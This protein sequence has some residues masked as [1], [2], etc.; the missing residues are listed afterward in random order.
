MTEQKAK[1]KARISKQLPQ[2]TRL[3]KQDLVNDVGPRSILCITFS[4]N[5]RQAWSPSC[6]RQ[7]ST[8]LLVLLVLLLLAR[9]VI[10]EEEPK[11][12][13]R[14]DLD[15]AKDICLQP[16]HDNHRDVLTR[17]IYH[18]ATFFELPQ[19]I[20]VSAWTVP[21][22]PSSSR[23]RFV[24]V[25]SQESWRDYV[26]IE[27]WTFFRVLRHTY[28]WEVVDGASWFE[29]AEELLRDGRRAPAVLLFMEHWGL[30]S[31]GPID[32]RLNG[33]S[34]WLFSDDLNWFGGPPA[35]AQKASAFAVADVLA[36]A[37]MPSLPAIFPE[38]AHKPRVH[39]P[40]AVSPMFELPM[41]T[42]PVPR[43]LLSGQTNALYPYRV[44]A[45]RRALAGDA[46]FKLLRHPGYWKNASAASLR[47]NSSGGSGVVG[48]AYAAALH[49]HLAA[50]TDGTVFNRSVAKVFEIPATGALLL[51]NAELVPVLADVGMRPGAH[52]VAY[53]AA[54][55][56]AVVDWVLHPAHRAAVDAI[57]AQGQA[58]VWARHTVFHRAAALDAAA[59]LHV[60]A[61]VAPSPA[62]AVLGPAPPAARERSA[63]RSKRASNSSGRPRRDAAAGLS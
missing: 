60:Q 34:V 63:R 56:D 44:L 4:Q 59:R 54:T 46:R 28:G 49:A 36:G 25:G 12:C 6:C 17:V 2:T 8:V 51:A 45:L 30:G 20:A 11:V 33:T 3:H 62:A 24:I 61:A 26:T 18:P 5:M 29:L 52:F 1:V 55:L 58:I 42:A 38:V 15:V 9:S 14:V 32:P 39:I 27:Y 37:Y 41:N 57:R 21:D 35:R 19:E 53:T 7:N 22:N 48:A 50:L 31:W 13:P 47:R 10:W 40:H 23:G 16:H 43:V